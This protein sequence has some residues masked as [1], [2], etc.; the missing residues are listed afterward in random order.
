MT[1][2]AGTPTAVSRQVIE[3][4]THSFDVDLDGYRSYFEDDY[5]RLSDFSC[6]SAGV[7]DTEL[8]FLGERL[9]AWNASRVLDVGC[10]RGRHVVP[11][12][13]AGYDVTGVDISLRNIELTQQAINEHQVT[14]LALHEDARELNLDHTVDV[15]LFMLSSFGYHTDT[16]NLRLLET[17]RRHVTDGGRIVI[18]QPNREQLVSNFVNRSWAEVGGHYYLMH[19]SLDLDT[20]VRDGWLNVWNP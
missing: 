8:S 12:A 10:G 20:G 2:T 14:A 7:I 9:R 4:P 13:R 3:R 15:A 6:A 1:R 17:V 18:D 19:Y 11:L 16:Q 5:W